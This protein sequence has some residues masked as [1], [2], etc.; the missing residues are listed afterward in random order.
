MIKKILVP[1]DGSDLSER[2]LPYATEVARRAKAEIVLT[3]SL[4]PVGVWDA[5][6]TA[7]NW[8]REEQAAKTYL[9]TVQE[10]LTADGHNVR[11]LPLQG[12]AAEAILGAAEKEKADL[13]TMSTHGRSG[14]MRW[15]LGS[16]ADRVI[17]LSPVPVLLI[18][19]REDRDDPPPRFERILVPL[20]G[21]DVAAK[22]LPFVKDFARLFN[23]DL[24]LYHA[25]S[26]TGAYPSFESA[27]AQ[28]MGELLETMQTEAQT[29]LA[30]TAKDL[31]AEGFHATADV[32]MALAAD[33]ILDATK[34]ANAGL[35]AIGTHGR[36]GLGR[37]VL[38]S[39][40]NA[41]V[42][43]AE[44]PCLLVHPTAP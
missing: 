3:S 41:V 33:G 8:E 9:T 16:I 20:D 43:R 44:I 19:P 24:V 11:T 21:S 23:S 38:G 32:S 2:I 29:M 17:Q 6:A 35:I 22:A 40:A 13:I 25:V 30:A 7:I 27:N 34:R 31:E 4:Q 15:L 18:R 10:R 1:L 5:T 37:A 14:I 39:V 42:R 36:S 12:E 28:I 26:T